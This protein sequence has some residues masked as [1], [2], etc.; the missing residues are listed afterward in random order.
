VV[1]LAF[2]TSTRY[3]LSVAIRSFADGVTK[4]FF[5]NGRPPRGVGWSS[6]EKVVRRKLDMLH[7][8]ERLSDLRSPPGNRL[9]ALGGE[10][11]GRFR[12][13]VNDQ[14]RLVFEWD[15]DGPSKVRVTDYHSDREE[16]T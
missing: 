12:I 3:I 2:Y 13:R 8:A 6:I 4:K 14:W 16:R 9:E 7:Y 10:L 15:A 5:I 11:R 1:E